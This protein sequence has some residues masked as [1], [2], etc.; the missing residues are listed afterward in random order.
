MKLGWGDADPNDKRAPDAANNDFV[1]PVDGTHRFGA[2]LLY[3]INASATAL[4]AGGSC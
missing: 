2:T 1:A 4:C 3:K